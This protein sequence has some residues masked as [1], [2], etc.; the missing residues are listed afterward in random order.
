MYLSPTPIDFIQRQ[1][2]TRVFCGADFT[3]CIG[4]KGEVYSWGQNLRGQLG[5][6]NLE[7]LKTPTLVKSL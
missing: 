5:H 4:S 3:F 1:A 7:V 6:G 2:I